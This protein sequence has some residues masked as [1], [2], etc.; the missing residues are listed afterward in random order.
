MVVEDRKSTS[1]KAQVYEQQ[2][3]TTDSPPEKASCCSNPAVPKVFVP[4]IALQPVQQCPDV[5][6]R[7]EPKLLCPAPPAA[8][9]DGV[10]VD[11]AAAAADAQGKG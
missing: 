9:G 1:L 11:E 5:L 3:E 8:G 10:D 7:V 2:N 6:R 4:L